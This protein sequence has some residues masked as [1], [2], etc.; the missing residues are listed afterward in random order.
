MPAHYAS[1]ASSKSAN[2]GFSVSS[3]FQLLPVC[4]M[5][6]DGVLREVATDRSLFINIP[7]LVQHAARA[8]MASV[9]LPLSSYSR[10]MYHQ[11]WTQYLIRQRPTR[12]IDQ[13][14][15]T[16]ASGQHHACLEAVKKKLSTPASSKYEFVTPA[17]AICPTISATDR[18]HQTLIVTE[19]VASVYNAG[20]R[21]TRFAEG[22]VLLMV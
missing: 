8:G 15:G 7:Q 9:L 14:E 22:L 4:C 5:R 19:A 10:S 2:I 1:R 11:T 21:S 12:S 16:C 3:A 6:V 20:M 18:S 17:G 13:Y